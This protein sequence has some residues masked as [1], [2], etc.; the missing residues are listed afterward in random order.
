VSSHNRPNIKASLRLDNIQIRLSLKLNKKHV[1]RAL[2]MF[3]DF[4]VSKLLL[5][6]DDNVLQE[7]VQDQLYAKANRT[8]LWAALV[9]KELKPVKS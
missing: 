3:I 4:K 2:E 6:T 1:S 5:I 9:L 8:F 7:T